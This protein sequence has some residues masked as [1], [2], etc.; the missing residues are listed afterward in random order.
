MWRVPLLRNESHVPRLRWSTLNRMLI[1]PTRS[2]SSRKKLLVTILRPSQ[3]GRS[4]HRDPSTSIRVRLSLLSTRW[5]RQP[6]IPLLLQLQRRR[7]SN[8]ASAISALKSS[9]RHPFTLVSLPIPLTRIADNVKVLNPH[10]VSPNYHAAMQ[11]V[12][13]TEETG[14]IRIVTLKREHEWTA[15]WMFGFNHVILRSA[16]AGTAVGAMENLLE[17]TSTLLLAALEND[18]CMRNM[19]P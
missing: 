15:A 6:G 9:V 19:G 1:I 7:T 11:A 18:G 12:Q 13:N 2:T 14:S 3:A 5:L 17:C 16:G 8:Q 10:M 4:K